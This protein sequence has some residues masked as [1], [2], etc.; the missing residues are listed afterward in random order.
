MLS[1]D[2]LDEL[3]SFRVVLWSVP[4]LSPAYRVKFRPITSSSSP[5]TFNVRK[6]KSAETM[7]F[8]FNRMN[9]QPV[10]SVV[11]APLCTKCLLFVWSPCEETLHGLLLPPVWALVISF[12]GNGTLRLKREYFFLE[13]K[14]SSTRLLV[15]KSPEFHT[16]YR[17]QWW[18]TSENVSICVSLV[19]V[20]VWTK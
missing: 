7:A 8:G 3:Y 12:Y 6:W 5:K 4:S 11:S 14:K 19:K 20:I 18:K 15:E 10:R 16:I 13:P 9:P 2:G 1:D 17:R